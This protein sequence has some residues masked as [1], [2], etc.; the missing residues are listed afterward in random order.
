MRRG[1]AAVPINPNSG[2]KLISSEQPSVA[3]SNTQ[4]IP[5]GATGGAIGSSDLSLTIMKQSNN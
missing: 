4:R 3:L 2:S 1:G 5:I